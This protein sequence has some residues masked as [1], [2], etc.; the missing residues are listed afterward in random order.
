MRAVARRKGAIAA[1][2]GD[3]LCPVRPH[4]ADIL[5]VLSS[6]PIAH[7]ACHGETDW[8]DPALSRLVLHDHQNRPLTVADIN[9]LHL[10]GA[11]AFLS[12]CS[13]ASP[14]PRLNAA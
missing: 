12:A 6:H 10:N 2:L 11:L 1:T 13:T 5:E 7:F 14:S 9:T 4:R 3:V 8:D